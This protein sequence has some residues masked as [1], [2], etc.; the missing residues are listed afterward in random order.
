[1]GSRVPGV[2]VLLT[3]PVQVRSYNGT[4]CLENTMREF[5]DSKPLVHMEEQTESRH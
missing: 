5:T 2:L 4:I 1:M 3:A